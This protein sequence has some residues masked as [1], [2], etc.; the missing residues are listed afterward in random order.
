MASVKQ[1]MQK[2]KDREKL[3]KKKVLRRRE[4]LRLHRK[5]EAEKEKSLETEY[6]ARRGDPTL[7]NEQRNVLLENLTGKAVKELSPEETAQRDELL[8]A[9][10]K[11][12]ILLLEELEKQYTEEQETRERTNK[13]LEAEG[14]VT[15]KDKMDLLNNKLQPEIID[16]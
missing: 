10:L 7:T 14:A 8:I 4:A 6:F 12:N 3:V 9:R 15:L 5:T 11:N 16:K 2:K 1:Q 13:L